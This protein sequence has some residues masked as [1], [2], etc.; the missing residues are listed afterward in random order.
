MIA[1]TTMQT[2]CLAANIYFEARGEPIDGQLLVADVVLNRVEST[3]F[4]DDVC[5]VV[6]EDGQ[7]S[8]TG[9]N[10]AIDDLDSFAVAYVLADDVLT[11]GCVLCS[12]A[13]YYH[14]KSVRPFW[15]KHMERVGI[16]GNHIF[17][18]E[19]KNHE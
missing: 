1:A 12:G 10:Y 7:F 2:L 4:A 14:E 17:Y 11:N 19:R 16:Y 15:A 13:T 18:K 3:K 8:W 5:S 9:S 6:F